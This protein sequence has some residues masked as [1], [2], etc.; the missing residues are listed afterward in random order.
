[1]AYHQYQ[2][3]LKKT[4]EDFKQG[5]RSHEIEDF[6]TTTLD[7]LKKSIRDLQAKHPR[8]QR[9]RDLTRLQQFYEAIT[10][11][12]EIVKHI[13]DNHEIIAFIWKTFSVDD[14]F[15][16]VIDAYESV[17]E[18]TPLLMQH[19]DVFR[20]KK[21]IICTLPLIYES[22][23][24]FQD[25]I[26]HYFQQPECQLMLKGS[27]DACKLRLSRFTSTIDRQ[28]DLIESRATASQSQEG[29]QD[30]Q[31]LR[32]IDDD[33][34]NAQTLQETQAVYIWLS[35]TN[36]DI[37]QDDFSKIRA[38]YSGTGRWL[39][40]NTDFKEWF[41]PRYTPTS[42]TLW[43]NG[44]RGAG[45][46][47]LAS[48]IV[49]EARKLNPASTVLFFYC[50][51]QN[52]ERNNF[53]ALGKSLLAQLLKH[54]SGLLPTFYE[55]ARNSSEATLTSPAV[56]KELLKIAFRNCKLAYIILDGLDEC[57]REQREIITQW[58]IKLVENLPN[59]ESY[60]LRCLFI[61]Q[62]DDAA[63]EDFSGLPSIK[64]R[65]EDNEH[66]IGEY[67]RVEANKPKKNLALTDEKV[68]MNANTVTGSVQE[69]CLEP[70]SDAHQP[71]EH[72][73]PNTTD[74]AI[75]ETKETRERNTFK[76]PRSTCQFCTVGFPSA[77]ERDEH[78]AQDHIA[79]MDLDK[80]FPTDRDIQQSIFNNQTSASGSQDVELGHSD[81]NM[82]GPA[83]AAIESSG[84]ELKSEPI[85][86]HTQTDDGVRRYACSH[87]DRTY[88]WRNDCKR[89]MNTHTGERKFVCNSCG[90]SFTRG[91]ILKKHYESRKGA[92]IQPQ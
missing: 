50:K 15:N 64:I 5:L 56:V 29:Q 24:G 32:K 86:Q 44:I 11:Y 58:F 76:C 18:K 19:L 65:S 60:G 67:S 39:L 4:L 7:D 66:D 92:C 49:E 38:D 84:S 8:L 71:L 55:K 89:H 37:D 87:C 72:V 22:I 75:L 34:F 79:V 46:S 91:G 31:R 48:L 6:K 40:E 70:I 59:R 51:H 63:Q 14:A 62:D 85:L 33:R 1:M 25:T 88:M 47:I 69:P 80:E 23:L 78:E 57:S 81:D 20:T 74:V 21:D 68:R 36:V 42:L 54:D 52:P 2:L 3:S 30:I 12:G 45:M 26:L 35:A 53:V 28:R 9:L 41:D 17:G 13:Y 83:T 16:K 61:S 90:K 10:Q 27:W 73:A 82:R 43:L 77:R